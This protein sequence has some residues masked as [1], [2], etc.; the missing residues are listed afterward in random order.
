M[1]PSARRDVTVEPRSAELQEEYQRRFRAA[2][3]YRDG[4][5]R[6]LCGEYF[7]RYVSPTSVLLDL[8]AGW[9]E[10]TRN[11]AAGTKYA[12]DLNPDCGARVAGHATF[13]QQDCSTTWPLDDGS[14]DVVFTSSFLEHLPSKDRV[15]DTLREAFRCLKPGGRIVCLGPNIKFV[16]GSYWDFW[17]HAIPIT[18]ASM[19]EALSLRGFRVTERV[20]RF[21]PYTM[22]GGRAPP[23]IAVSLYLKLPFAWRFFGKQFLVVAQK[24]SGPVGDAGAAA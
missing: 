11:I 23:L 16:P 12:M 1:A 8:G 5:W 9:G 18:D 3:D 17:D 19:A 7:S 22:S 15:E 21:L 24:P 10:F 2:G 20:E 6:I 4:V 13:L 14:L